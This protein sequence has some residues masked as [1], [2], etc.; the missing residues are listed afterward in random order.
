M[1]CGAK[2]HPTAPAV[3]RLALASPK[4][5]APAAPRRGALLGLVAA[6][7]AAPRRVARA[8]GGSLRANADLKKVALGMGYHG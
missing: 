6:V 4:R 7:A 2:V 3:P 5:P 8:A 1:L